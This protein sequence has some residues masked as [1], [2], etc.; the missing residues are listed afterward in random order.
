[1]KA[2]QYNSVQVQKFNHVVSLKPKETKTFTYQLYA[3]K[4]G[5]YPVGPLLVRSGDVLGITKPAEITFESN[6]LTVYPRIEPLHRLGLPSHSPFGI[7]KHKNPIFEDPSRI[8]G[9]RDYQVG[10]SLR[11]IDWKTSAST[12]QLQVK[13][14]EASIDMEITILLDLHIDSYAME[15]RYDA[16]ELAI[17]TAASIANWSTQHKQ[18]VGLFTNGLDPLTEQADASFLRPQKGNQYLMGILEALSRLSV[19]TSI[20]LTELIQQ[21][22]AKLNWGATLILITGFYPPTLLEQIIQARKNGLNI[23]LILIGHVPNHIEADAH[24]RQFGFT[25]LLC[26]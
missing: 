16:T 3:Y 12:G 7:I 2:C 15:K 14:F 23:V 19:S 6:C 21:G 26:S 22:Q 25:F 24:A 20:T 17:T 1:M 10:D 18:A 13:Q 8:Y 11:R 5:Y 4:R 9:K